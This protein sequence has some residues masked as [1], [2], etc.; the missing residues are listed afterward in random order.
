M[1]SFIIFC[2]GFSRSKKIEIGKMQN[3]RCHVSRI[4]TVNKTKV[5]LYTA[6]WMSDIG[7]V[8]KKG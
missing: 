2:T 5:K 1:G 6:V 4:T 7:I 3:L 8:E